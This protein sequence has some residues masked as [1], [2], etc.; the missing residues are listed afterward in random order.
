MVDRH[1]AQ[2]RFPWPIHFWKHL[3]QKL[4][5]HGV[6]T[7]LSGNCMQK[8]QFK[9]LSRT[10][11]TELSFSFPFPFFVS[12]S[13]ST[14][15][16]T[17]SCLFLAFSFSV[18]DSSASIAFIDAKSSLELPSTTAAADRRGSPEQSGQ[19]HCNVE[20]SVSGGEAKQATCQGVAHMLQVRVSSV[21]GVA[22]QR[23][24]APSASQGSW[25]LSCAIDNN[26][27]LMRRIGDV[28]FGNNGMILGG[29]YRDGDCEGGHCE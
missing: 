10:S 18:N 19:C 13:S 6:V 2:V 5:P 22:L 8:E 16:L 17:N 29:I 21:G 25:M 20:T 4:W 27:Q 26:P 12:P 28:G 23:M 15:P 24:H 11:K 3:R 1:L 7:G 9:L 14:L